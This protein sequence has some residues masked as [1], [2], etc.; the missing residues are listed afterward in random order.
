MDQ[1]G[2]PD[3]ELLAVSVRTSSN[4]VATKGFDLFNIV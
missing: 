2:L 3:L 4:P 1:K